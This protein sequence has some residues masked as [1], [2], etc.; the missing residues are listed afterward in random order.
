MRYIVVWT[1]EAE[2][3]LAHLWIQSSDRTSLVSASNAIDA[4]LSQRPMDVGEE[5]RPGAR[6]LHVAP[7]MVD[8]RVMDAD[9]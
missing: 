2:E 9:R 5:I 4:Q 6:L 3:E 8:Y 1:R 7:L